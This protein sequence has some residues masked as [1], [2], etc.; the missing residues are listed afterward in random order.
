[1]WVPPPPPFFLLPLDRLD[2]GT[3]TGVLAQVVAFLMP[4]RVCQLRGEWGGLMEET[5]KRTLSLDKGH[6][7]RRLY[8]SFDGGGGGI[9]SKLR[10]SP[11][12]VSELQEAEI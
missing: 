2:K 7:S 3:V 4:Q 10:L 8:G 9:C 12:E 1:M 5:A 11:E 6:Q